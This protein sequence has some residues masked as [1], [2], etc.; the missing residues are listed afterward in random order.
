MSLESRLGGAG[1]G[2]LDVSFS[3]S[4]HSMPNI[5]DQGHEFSLSLCLSQYFDSGAAFTYLPCQASR[6]SVRL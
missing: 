3:V 6:V 4:I 1:E 2:H 5:E